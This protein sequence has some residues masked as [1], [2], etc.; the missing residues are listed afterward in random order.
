MPALFEINAAGKTHRVIGSRGNHYVLA[1]GL[2]LLQYVRDEWHRFATTTNILRHKSQLEKDVK[3]RRRAP[4]SPP[5]PASE[6]GTHE[7]VIEGP[8]GNAYD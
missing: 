5:P 8:A 7:Q 2:K 4:A 3:Q 1:R 6:P